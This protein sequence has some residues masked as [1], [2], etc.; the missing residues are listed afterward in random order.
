MAETSKPATTIAF[1][2]S[3]GAYSHLACRAV[4]PDFTA[5]PC[6]S[7][8]DTFQAVRDGL[9]KYAMIPVDNSVAGRVADIHHLLPRS[10]L[11]IIGEH[12]QPVNHHLLAVPGA[13]IADIRTVRSHV[14]ALGQCRNIIRE[15][16]IRPVVAADTAGSAAE[17]AEKGDKTIAAIASEL[18]AETYGLVSLRANIED[19]THNTTRFLIMAEEAVTPPRDTPLPVVTSFVFRVRNV[20]AALYKALGGFATN[21]VNMTKLESYIVDGHFVAAQFLAEVEGHPEERSVRLA[22]EELQFFSREV[23]ILGVYPAHPYRFEARAE[24]E[25]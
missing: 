15:L 12:Y 22:F 6:A 25:D 20:P 8:E 13:T 1:Q 18:A 7:F 5:L 11:H 2:G 9:A 19:E 24:L 17:V 4:F 16:G 10:G 21:G 14:H 23:K 3:P